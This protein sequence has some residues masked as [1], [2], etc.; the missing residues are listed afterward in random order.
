MLQQHGGEFCAG[1]PLS[2]DVPAA[3]PIAEPPAAPADGPKPEVVVRVDSWT[4]AQP[5]TPPPNDSL[6]Q[7]L[8]EGTPAFA[9]ASQQPA[10]LKELPAAAVTPVNPQVPA[11][12]PNDGSEVGIGD[13]V[14]VATE[15]DGGNANPY[16]KFLG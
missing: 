1:N 16:W 2:P 14:S 8:L 4:D 13:S 5:R 9:A 12:T 7:T 6:S 15:S 3:K 11:P 10:G